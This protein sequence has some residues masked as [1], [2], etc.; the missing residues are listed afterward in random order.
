MEVKYIKRGYYVQYANCYGVV[1]EKAAIIVDPGKYFDEMADFFNENKDKEKLILITHGHFDHIGGAEELREKTGVKIAI[2]QEEAE[3][4]YNPEYNLSARFNLPLKPF[5][6]DI[7]FTDG[8]NFNLGDLCIEVLFTPGH[9]KGSVCYKIKNVLF[10]GDTLFYETVGRT[11]LVGSSSKALKNSLDRIMFAVPDETIVYPGHGEQTD[12][13][14][15]KEY[16]P[17]VQL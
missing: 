15:E 7:T 2:G 8:Q 13:A 10:S 4:L 6:A 9:S 14:H 1:S 16:N 11:D 5:H 17:F 12:I 3:A